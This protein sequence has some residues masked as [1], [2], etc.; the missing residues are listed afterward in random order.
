MLNQ[1]TDLSPT[2]PKDKNDWRPFSRI[3]CR[4]F[5]DSIGTRNRRWLGNITNGDPINHPI[6]TFLPVVSQSETM[7]LQAAMHVVDLQ[8]AT[9][10]RNV[11]YWDPTND[12]S[13]AIK[14]KYIHHLLAW[15]AEYV[16]ASCLNSPHGTRYVEISRSESTD[17]RSCGLFKK[18]K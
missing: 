6:S 10:I 18:T 12:H 16:K 14:L 17:V 8:E 9:S 1:Q 2:N 4:Y 5:G 15:I 11:K 13:A 7:N 3:T